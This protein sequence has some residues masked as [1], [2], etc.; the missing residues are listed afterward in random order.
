MEMFKPP[1]PGEIIREDCLRPLKPVGDGGGE[2]AGRVA[3]VLV[4]IAQ[5]P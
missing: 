1:H 4:G 5:R 2:G 3:S